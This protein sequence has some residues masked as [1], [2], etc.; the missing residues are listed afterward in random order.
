MAV[1]MA[2]LDESQF[3]GGLTGISWTAAQVLSRSEDAIE[4][5]EN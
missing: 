3:K 1:G 4:E 5:L 2:T